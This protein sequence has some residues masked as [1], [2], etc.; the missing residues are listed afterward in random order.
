MGGAGWRMNVQALFLL[1][2]ASHC[3][4]CFEYIRELLNFDKFTLSFSHVPGAVSSHVILLLQMLFSLASIIL[5][6]S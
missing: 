3:E 5:T 2:Y 6:C 4:S 1:I